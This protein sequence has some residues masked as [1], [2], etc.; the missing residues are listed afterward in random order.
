MA[1]CCDNGGTVVRLGSETAVVT[2]N[3]WLR[4]PR[5]DLSDLVAGRC[6]GTG[7]RRSTRLELPVRL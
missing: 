5:R 7:D 3:D 1:V 2:S 4:A 6:N